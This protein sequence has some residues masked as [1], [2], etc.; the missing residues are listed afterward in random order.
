MT[1]VQRSNSLPDLGAAEQPP[2]KKGAALKGWLPLLDRRSYIYGVGFET[3]RRNEVI[4][5]LDRFR[6]EGNLPKL[7]AAVRR[8]QLDVHIAETPAV[9]EAK[10]VLARATRL[11]LIC[12]NV[13]RRTAKGT[14]TTK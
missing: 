2:A 4:E 1:S 8:A 6:A 13:A 9:L 5:N 10:N 12:E 14:F 7:W 3:V 11:K